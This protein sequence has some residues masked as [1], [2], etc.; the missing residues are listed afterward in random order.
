[1]SAGAD[2]EGH[3]GQGRAGDADAGE[4]TGVGDVDIG[5]VP[6]LA[7]LVEHG[8]LRRAAHASA[9][10]FMDGGIHNHDALE[11]AFEEQA[12]DRIGAATPFAHAAG[13]A[14]ELDLSAAFGDH[15]DEALLLV[16]EGARDSLAHIIYG[17]TFST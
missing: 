13:R 11:E 10:R 2:G 16:C 12:G 1:M 8:I 15:V 17:P 14:H 6:A 3:D 7:V 9:A 4:G 5:G